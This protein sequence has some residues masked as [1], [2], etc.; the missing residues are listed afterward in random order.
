MAR[1]N[2]HKLT[3]EVRNL[4]KAGVFNVYHVDLDDAGIRWN[5]YENEYRQLKANPNR[6]VRE[7]LK[8]LVTSQAEKKI[9]KEI[10]EKVKKPSVKWCKTKFKGVAP[11]LGKHLD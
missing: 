6:Y 11:T 10:E 1:Q 5:G 3:P 8:E 9:D 7:H 2:F 4:I